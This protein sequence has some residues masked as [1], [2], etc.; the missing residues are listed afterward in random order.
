MPATCRRGCYPLYIYI[1]CN[2]KSSYCTFKGDGW[3]FVIPYD[4]IFR[5]YFFII[6]FFLISK[7]GQFLELI[8]PTLM[9]LYYNDDQYIVLFLWLA[10]CKMATVPMKNAKMPKDIQ[11]LNSCFKN[12]HNETVCSCC[13]WCIETT[14]LLRIKMYTIG[15]Y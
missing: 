4:G 13:L 8:W 9:K 2:G 12:K 7:L 15:N 5:C 11:I 10:S 6:I 14:T 3:K 1:A